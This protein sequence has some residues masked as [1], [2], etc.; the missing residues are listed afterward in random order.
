MGVAGGGLGLGVAQDLAHRRQAL[1][2]HHR[3]RGERVTKIVDPHVVEPGRLAHPPP[4]LLQVLQVFA[5]PGASDDIGVAPDPLGIGQDLERRRVERDRLGAGLR[6][7]QVNPVTPNVLPLQGLDLR[8]PRARVEQQAIR[9]HRRG[10]ERLLLVQRLAQAR[11]LF[12]RQEPL[13]LA[14]PVL[15]D[16]VAGIGPVRPQVPGLGQVHH[17]RQHP[18]RPVGLVGLVLHVVM[19]RRHLFAPQRQHADRAQGG[20]DVAVHGMPVLHLGARLAVQG[21]VFLQEPLRQ[22]RHRR[23]QALGLL[24]PGSGSGRRRCRR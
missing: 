15:A 20:K 23:R 11:E 13:V 17:L 10:G 7:G 6:I 3:L 22:L 14:L 5:L 8:Q 24:L 16:V 19:Q 2:R 12:A 21:D 18:E 4:G 9:R 1:A